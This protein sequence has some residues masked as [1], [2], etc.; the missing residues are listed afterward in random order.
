MQQREVFLNQL[1][2]GDG[3]ESWSG[4]GRDVEKRMEKTGSLTLSA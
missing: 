2:G 1:V 4:R 3:G